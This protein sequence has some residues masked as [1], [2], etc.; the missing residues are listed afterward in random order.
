[1]VLHLS[2]SN[3]VYIYLRTSQLYSQSIHISIEAWVGIYSTILDLRISEVG[4]VCQFS[5]KF[6]SELA[7]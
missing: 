3:S 6:L 1:M 7:K 5:E 2:I 4:I